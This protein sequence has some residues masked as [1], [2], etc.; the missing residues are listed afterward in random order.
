MCINI[1]TSNMQ[2]RPRT[3]CRQ[4]MQSLQQHKHGLPGLTMQWMLPTWPLVVSFRGV[5]WNVFA[6]MF[7]AS[8]IEVKESC[9]YRPG[10]VWRSLWRTRWARMNQKP[11]YSM[12]VCF[13]GTFPEAGMQSGALHP[14]EEHW[15]LKS[16][17]I[18]TPW[19]PCEGEL[20]I[21]RTDAS[22]SSFVNLLMCWGV[23][24]CTE[25]TDST[26]RVVAVVS[27]YVG[28]TS[29]NKG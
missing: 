23:D 16:T 5:S 28:S 22:L 9:P 6:R 13:W 24:W 19:Y 20:A 11:G 21:G 2:R 14:C 8:G 4:G 12:C 29:P 26:I 15:S 17:K 7:S 3:T 27:E 25:W 10:G 18:R 1:Y